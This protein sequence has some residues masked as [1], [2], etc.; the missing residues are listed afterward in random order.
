VGARDGQDHGKVVYL[1]Q[2]TFETHF[3]MCMYVF[4]QFKTGEDIVHVL[5]FLKSGVHQIITACRDIYGQY[6]GNLN[7]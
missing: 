1:D 3:E 2:S 7:I 6:N 5:L 4:S